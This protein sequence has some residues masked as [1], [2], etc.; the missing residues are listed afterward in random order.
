MKN[1]IASCLAMTILVTA[2]NCFAAPGNTWY[3][4][5]ALGGDAW[6]NSKTLSVKM[7]SGQTLPLKPQSD[8]QFAFAGGLLI[9]AAQEIDTLFFAEQLEVLYQTVDNKINKTIPTSSFAN[10]VEETQGPTAVIAFLPGLVINR[11]WVAYGKLGYAFS[12]F[13]SNGTNSGIFGP[14][15]DHTELAS[16]LQLGLGVQRHF[17]KRWI[18]RAEYDYTD[19]GSFSLA[20][21]NDAGTPGGAGGIVTTHYTISTNALMLNAIYSF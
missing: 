8:S 18:L 20:G 14:N 5:L 3:G 11:N 17:P 6:Q 10:S 13:E 9:G 21:K 1:W 19:Y 15:G 12:Q 16:G 2:N 4:G 7:S